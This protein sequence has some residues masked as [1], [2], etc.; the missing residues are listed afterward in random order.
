MRLINTDI[1][2]NPWN[3]ATVLLMAL[4]ALFGLA[5]IVQEPAE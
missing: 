4:I 5:L 1:I 3:W 2:S